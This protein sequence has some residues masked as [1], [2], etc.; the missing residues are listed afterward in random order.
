M[1]SLAPGSRGSAEGRERNG[2]VE[3]GLAPFEGY[4]ELPKSQLGIPAGPVEK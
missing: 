3:R 2:G 1:K 4:H